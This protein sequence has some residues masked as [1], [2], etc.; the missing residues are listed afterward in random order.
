MRTGRPQADA[1]VRASG[2]SPLLNSNITM[3]GGSRLRSST[4]DSEGNA[5]LRELPP[6]TVLSITVHREG[7]EVHRTTRP[8]TLAP[9]EEGALIIELHGGTTL[10]GMMIDQDGRP[11]AGQGVRVGPAESRSRA[12]RTWRDYPAALE[13]TTN[14]VGS[15][16]FENLEPG[17]WWVWPTPDSRASESAL[18]P[19]TEFV[20]IDGHQETTNIVLRVRRGLFIRGQVMNPLDEPV[21][22]VYLVLTPLSEDLLYGSGAN[23][24]ADGSFVFGPLL[25]GLYE[26]QPMRHGELVLPLPLVVEAGMQNAVLRMQIGGG[27]RG[28]VVDVKTN[29][30]VQ[31]NLK[32]EPAERYRQ[33]HGRGIYQYGGA[34]FHY[35]PL[36]EGKYNVVATTTGGLVGI[37]PG[38][39]VI[40]GSTTEGVVIRVGPAAKVRVFYEGEE[41]WGNF[42]VR[43]GDALIEGIRIHTGTS[44]LVDAPPGELTVTRSNSKGAPLDEKTARLKAGEE[45]EFSFIGGG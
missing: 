19:V 21:A 3:F 11:V 28:T 2:T 36:A 27:I 7:T 38:I 44:V 16:S 6:E 42:Q 15:F 33:S 13:T 32:V 30:S 45:K 1:T 31:A 29:Q 17:G 34:E 22:S 40:A 43:L 5:H 18:V 14:T 39:Q 12:L 24:K 8:V 4:T 37:A 23:S 25:P 10:A 9:G 41:T 35:K 26:L 20:Q